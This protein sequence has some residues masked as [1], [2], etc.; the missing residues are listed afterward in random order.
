MSMARWSN[1]MSWI[2]LLFIV[3]SAHAQEETWNKTQCLRQYQLLEKANCSKDGFTQEQARELFKSTANNSSFSLYLTNVIVN[4]TLV[5]NETVES[6]FIPTDN[7]T[8][9]VTIYINGTETASRSF[10]YKPHLGFYEYWARLDPPIRVQEHSEFQF[11]V[12]L[13]DSNWHPNRTSALHLL[14]TS[15]IDVMDFCT[16]GISRRCDYLVRELFDEHPECSIVDKYSFQAKYAYCN[17][18]GKNYYT[19]YCK[20]YDNN[21]TMNSW[22]T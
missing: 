6:D 12:H 3:C 22:H 17:S 16:V 9:K 10:Q 20:L 2:L 4:L 11:T 8:F 14:S 13:N 18:S 7:E 19:F 15:Y 5:N 1:V 21:Q